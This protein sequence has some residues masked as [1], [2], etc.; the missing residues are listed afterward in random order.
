MSK[1]LSKTIRDT[2][3]DVRGFSHFDLDISDDV[4]ALCEGLNIEPNG[5]YNNFGQPETLEADIAKFLTGMGNESA[6]AKVVALEIS[7]INDEVKQ[8][9]GVDSSWLTLRPSEPSDAFDIPR[10]HKDGKFFEG[11][12]KQRKVIALLTGQDH[13]LIADITSE[14]HKKINKLYA[15]GQNYDSVLRSE[16]AEQVNTSSISQAHDRQG[17]VFTV[18]EEM[19]TLH[20]EPPARS[21]RLFL[22]VVPGTAEQIEALRVRWNEPPSSGAVKPTPPR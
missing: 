13:T 6:D 21:K 19:A 11:D 5:D 1:N 7:K 4:W 8:A 20:S 18:G 22:S 9:F 14:E 2:F 3:E 10:W 15:S 17:S 12:E 16:F